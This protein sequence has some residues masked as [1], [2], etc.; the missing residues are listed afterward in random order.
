[1]ASW[2]LSLLVLALAPTASTSQDGPAGH[3]MERLQGTWQFVALEVQGEAKPAEDVAQYTAVLQGDL[4]TVSKGKEVA[5]QVVFRV[6]PTKTPKTMEFIDI[7]RARSMRGI[8][9]LQGETLKICDRDVK[10]GDRPTNFATTPDSG[11]VLVTLRRLKPGGRRADPMAAERAKLLGNWRFVSMEVQG[12]HKP[13]TEFSKYKVVFQDDQWT[14]SEDHRIAAQS[15]F[16]MDPT[17]TPKTIDI[18]DIDKGRIIRGV[19]KLEGDTFTVCDRGAEKGGRP[20]EFATRP[21]SGLVL[22]VLARAKP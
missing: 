3:E 9:S 14:V 18:V 5:A 7:N 2:I 8:Y 22:V 6:D 17:K 20:V 15:F 13:D 4:W 19:Y 1:M 10:K 12:E 21:D 11:L 16:R